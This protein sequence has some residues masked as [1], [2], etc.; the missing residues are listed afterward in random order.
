VHAHRSLRIGTVADRDNAL[1]H[2]YDVDRE[3]TKSSSNA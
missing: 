2:A 3:T 1:L